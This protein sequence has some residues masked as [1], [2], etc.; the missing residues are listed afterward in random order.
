MEKLKIVNIVLIGLL[1]IL[2][3]TM[4]I[5]QIYLV[6]SYKYI[7]PV[8]VKLNYS[9]NEA[10]KEWFYNTIERVASD[11][12]NDHEYRLNVYDCTDFSR[13]LRL[14]LLNLGI[15]SECTTGLY[16]GQ[17]GSPKH[18]WITIYYNNLEI[19]IESTG[20]YI[21]DPEDYSLNYRI[22]KHNYCY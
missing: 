1:L 21:I 8:K 22:T 16:T 13:E 12:S 14:R 7:K 19:P 2:V 15:K 17:E 11:V 10:H 6:Q 9:D 20:G 18:T 4:F 3:I 5:Y